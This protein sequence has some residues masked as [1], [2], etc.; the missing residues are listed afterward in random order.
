MRVSDAQ[1]PTALND[2]TQYAL[3]VRPDKAGQYQVRRCKNYIF[4]R[5]ATGQTALSVRPL[6]LGGA[7]SGQPGQTGAVVSCEE[8]GRSSSSTSRQEVGHRI[9]SGE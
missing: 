2:R 9:R 3:S 4:H 5:T 8:A 1:Q 7:D 6:P